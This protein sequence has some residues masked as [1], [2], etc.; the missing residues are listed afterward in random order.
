MC[1]CERSPSELAP[2]GSYVEWE[3]VRRRLIQAHHV[4]LKS[5]GGARH[6][7]NLILL[8]TLHHDNYGGRLTREAVT[9][10]LRKR[11]DKKV[12]RFGSIDDSG[13]EVTGRVVRFVIPDNDEGVSIFFTD[14]H[15][16]FWLSQARPSEEGMKRARSLKGG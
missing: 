2:T 16:G 10:A 1:L 9:A 7:G 6:A 11:R 13:S 12:V 3:E 8:C 4:D 14:E 5:G 15:V